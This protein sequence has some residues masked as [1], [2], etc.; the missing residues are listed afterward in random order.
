MLLYLWPL[1]NLLHKFSGNTKQVHL[2]F[3]LSTCYSHISQCFEL[4]EQKNSKHCTVQSYPWLCSWSHPINHL[5]LP[6]TRLR[7][8]RIL[9]VVATEYQRRVSLVPSQVLEQMYQDILMHS[10]DHR[11]HSH[12]WISEGHF[13]HRIITWLPLLNP[14]FQCIFSLL[15]NTFWR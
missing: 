15:Q 2:L 9:F 7:T 11:L 8:G 13:Q 5:T 12:C 10:H 6:R 3:T 14:V 4:L 1:F